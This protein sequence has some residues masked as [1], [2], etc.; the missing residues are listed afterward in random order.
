MKQRLLKFSLCL[1]MLILLCWGIA[2]QTKL[3]KCVSESLDGIHY[4]LFLKSSSFKRGDI[5]FIPD[6]QVQYAGEKS[7]AKRIFGLPGDRISKDSEGIKITSQSSDFKTTDSKH[8]SLL[9]KTSKGEL[10]TPLVIQVIPQG[11]VFVGGD[12]PKSFDSRYEEFGLVP[13]DK[14]WGKAAFTW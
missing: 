2:S 11:Y 1:G 13:L 12:N 3:G 4:A 7:L 14:V 10:L 5:I 6:Y 9:E 8:L